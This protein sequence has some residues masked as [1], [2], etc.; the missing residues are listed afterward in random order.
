MV[1]PNNRFRRVTFIKKCEKWVKFKT[2]IRLTQ[3]LPL[4]YITKLIMQ[5]LRLN[6][7]CRVIGY[8]LL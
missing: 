5:F 4:H 3:T 2:L 7:T 1:N 8:S 6:E